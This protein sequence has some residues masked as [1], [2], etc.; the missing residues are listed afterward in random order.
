MLSNC[1]LCGN[2]TENTFQVVLSG[3]SHVFDS[4]EC[5][6]NSVAPTCPHCGCRIVGHGLESNGAMYCCQ[7]CAREMGGIASD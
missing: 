7:H 5:A 6:I 3:K 4:F 2:E 1:E